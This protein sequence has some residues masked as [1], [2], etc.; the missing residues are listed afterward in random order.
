VHGNQQQ[1]SR[2]SEKDKSKE[3][4]MI[5]AKKYELW[6]NNVG[7]KRY[8]LDEKYHRE[9]GPAI[10]LADGGK[11]WYLNGKHHREGGPA[12][13]YADGTKEWYLNGEL[14]REDGPAV[15]YASGFKYW[16][17]NGKH[18]RED[19]P[20]VEYADGKKEWWIDGKRLTEAEFNTRKSSCPDGE[21][22]TFRGKKYRLVAE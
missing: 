21:T 20:A 13:E 15:E 5:G 6:V 11:E 10:E 16:Y 2:N 19:G 22:I 9:D 18:H 12:I 8:Y 17:L 1:T 3:R 4:V 14:H 7:T